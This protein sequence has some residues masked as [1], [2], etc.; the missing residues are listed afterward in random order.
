MQIY[1]KVF[2]ICST[3][4]KSMGYYYNQIKAQCDE[5]GISVSELCR[6]AAVDRTLMDR[7][8]KKDPTSLETLKKIN[9]A[10]TDIRNAQAQGLPG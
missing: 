5:L 6:E 10:L 7:W 1:I 3:K 4:F 8:R 9:D 2:Y